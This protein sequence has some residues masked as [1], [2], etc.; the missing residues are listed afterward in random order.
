MSAYT[1]I[2]V[3]YTGKNCDNLESEIRDSNH[4]NATQLLG[5]R[6]NYSTLVITTNTLI[7]NG[8]NWEQNDFNE[9]SLEEISVINDIYSKPLQLIS[10]HLD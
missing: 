5:F 3:L 8:D 10:F 4:F 6:L 9:P 1:A 2:G 7:K